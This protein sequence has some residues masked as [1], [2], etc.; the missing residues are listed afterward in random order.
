[1]KSDSAHISD[2]S[3]KDIAVGR[4]ETGERLTRRPWGSH[5]GRSIILLVLL[6]CGLYWSSMISSRRNGAIRD[7][8]FS[9]GDSEYSKDVVKCSG[10][11]PCGSYDRKVMCY[12]LHPL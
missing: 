6:L 12:R 9:M 7:G 11:S 2:K 1:M 8:G 4:T 10:K 5:T 3:N